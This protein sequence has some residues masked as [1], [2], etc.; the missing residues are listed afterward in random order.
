MKKFF[1]SQKIINEN[2]LQISIKYSQ[3]LEILRFIK[4][5]LP[6]IKIL[7]PI[8]LKESFKICLKEALNDYE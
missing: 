4:T 7:A 1:K 5:W 6:D 2:P 3:E 8:E